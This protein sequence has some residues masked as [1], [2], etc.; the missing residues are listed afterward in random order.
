ME[1]SEALMDKIDDKKDNG[2]SFDLISPKDWVIF[3]S[4]INIS[5]K[6]GSILTKRLD[7]IKIPGGDNIIK[8]LFTEM[9]FKKK[10][11]SME[12]RLKAMRDCGLFG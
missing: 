12:D 2:Y 6:H 5:K 9:S 10:G 11:Y 7:K 3:C 4:T 8:E 1:S